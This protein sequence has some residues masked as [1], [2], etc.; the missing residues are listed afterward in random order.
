MTNNYGIA[1]VLEPK[2]VLPTSAWKLDN[3]RY[4]MEG[5]MRIDVRRIHLEGTSFK[6][7]CLEA[8]DNDQRIRQKI[9]DIVIRRGKLHNPVTDT[10]GL[11]YGTVSEIADDYDNLKGF[12]PGE[13]VICNASL[14]SIPLYINK[15]ISIDRAFGQI[16]VEGYCIVN[17]GVPVIRRP[18]E[19]PIKLLLYILNESGTIYR[20]CS[21]AV[22]KRRFLIVGNNLLSN[23][24]FGTAIRKVARE[25]AEIVCLL[26]RKTDTVLRGESIERLKQHVFSEIHYVDI[27]KPLECIERINGASRFD[28][29][30]NCADI[31]GAETINILATKSGG[32]VI[33]ANLINNYNIA[34][35][36]TES[37]SRQLDI[38]CADGYLEAYDEFDFDIVRELIPYI[39]GAE[40]AQEGV[41]DDLTHPVGK[42]SR[43]LRDSGVRQT[44]MEDF[45]CESHAMATVLDDMLTVAKYDCN[46]LIT[47]ETGAGKG[48]VA[49]MI[50]KNSNRK[51]QPFIKVTCA[52]LNAAGMEGE[53]FGIEEG[54]DQ[55]FPSGKKGMFELADNGTLFLDEIGE[56]PQDL[57]AKLLRVIQDGEYFRVG[58]TS[59]VKANV[60]I[61]SATNRELEDLIDAGLFRRDLYYKLNV[62]RIRVPALRERTADIPAL[63]EHFL[64][65]YGERFSIKRTISRDAVEY[66]CQCDWPGNTRELENVVQRLMISAGSE[67]ISL[68][69]V[70]REMHTDVFDMN[71]F[72]GQE[73][74]GGEVNM[75]VMVDNFEKNIIRHALEKYGSTRK[76]AKAIG[77]SQTQLVRKKNKY[78]I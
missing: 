76:A 55:N 58:G 26:D 66:L 7:I 37:I 61:I 35:Y 17:S 56:M 4:L 68:I 21:T 14:A 27:L 71:V 13:E 44:I 5:E 9:M 38:R 51:M 6:E 50:H 59:S 70:M 73:T 22:G 2:Q 62:V 48:K 40:E 24:L 11:L 63:V 77:I 49:N 47:G 52:S 45:V 64:E 57:Q 36:I 19:L 3:S 42:K 41:R 12:R 39:E 53:L 75:E 60:R 30:V 1:R 18:E 65:S 15:I 23:L 33:F 8:N 69:D 31:T 29:S 28:L 72:G 34:L 20:I 25:D 16:E 54:T 10:G 78:G 46:V 43:F 67:E 32:T 74:E